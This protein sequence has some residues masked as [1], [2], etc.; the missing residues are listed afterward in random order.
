MFSGMKCIAVVHPAPPVVHSSLVQ[1][2]DWFRRADAGRHVSEACKPYFKHSGAVVSGPQAS[3]PPCLAP[4]DLALTGFAVRGLTAVQR[5]PY[6][7][8]RI[9]TMLHTGSAGQATREQPGSHQDG[10]CTTTTAWTED[11]RAAFTVGLHI[12]GKEQLA[13]IAALVPGRTVRAPSVFCLSVTCKSR[14]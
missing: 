9:S 13:A 14:G 10:A 2:P 7:T 5:P 3:Q 4:D 6:L 1:L 8:D 11:E 12:V